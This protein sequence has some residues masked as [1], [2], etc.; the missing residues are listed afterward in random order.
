MLQHWLRLAFVIFSI[1]NWNKAAARSVCI[2][3]ASDAG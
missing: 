2:K 1:W 3:I